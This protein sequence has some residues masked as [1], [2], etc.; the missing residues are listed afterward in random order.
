MA[1]T[2]EE[3]DTELTNQVTAGQ[4]FLRNAYQAIVDG[5]S[6]EGVTAQDVVDSA[7]RLVAAG[8]IE[9]KYVDRVPKKPNTNYWMTRMYKLVV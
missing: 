9:K 8:T 3:L 7:N 4:G 5:G 1:W 6:F 2:T